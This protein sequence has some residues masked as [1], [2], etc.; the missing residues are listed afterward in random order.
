MRVCGFSSISSL[1]FPDNHDI[2]LVG[3]PLSEDEACSVL[4]ICR[5]LV[6]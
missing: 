1:L 5:C 4:T 6:A 3:F 2:Y